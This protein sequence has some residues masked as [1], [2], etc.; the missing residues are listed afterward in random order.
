[1]RWVFEIICT[2]TH[3]LKY[4][5][6]TRIPLILPRTRYWWEHFH[7]NPFWETYNIRT[8]DVSH[9]DVIRIRILCRNCKRSIASFRW[10]YNELECDWVLGRIRHLLNNLTWILSN[11]FKNDFPLFRDFRNFKFS[12]LD[13]PLLYHCDQPRV[14]SFRC[15][16]FSWE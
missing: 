13:V 15:F 9:F 3:S 7:E 4:R 11:E 14:S 1:M 10:W 6:G 5:D 16:I 12:I 2:R 8:F